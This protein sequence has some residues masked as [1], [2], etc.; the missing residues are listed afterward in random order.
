MWDAEQEMQ[1]S[2]VFVSWEARQIDLTPVPPR[3]MDGSIYAEPWHCARTAD[4]FYASAA[5]KYKGK[6]A[7]LQFLVKLG[8]KV[9]TDGQGLGR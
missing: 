9:M 1:L 6:R 8:N 5:K 2:C 3:R 7:R 4:V